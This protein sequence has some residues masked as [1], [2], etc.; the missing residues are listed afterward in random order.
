[1]GM[2]SERLCAGRKA[3]TF[4]KSSSLPIFFLRHHWRNAGR[5]KQEPT[6]LLNRSLL[7]TEVAAFAYFPEKKHNRAKAAS[8]FQWSAMTFGAG[9]PDGCTSYLTGSS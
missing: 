6:S 9:N 7:H 2:R 5:L 8:Q 1:M 4:L 3:S